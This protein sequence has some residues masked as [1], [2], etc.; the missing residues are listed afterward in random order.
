MEL[1]AQGSMRLGLG[2][3]HST[4]LF[5]SVAMSAICELPRGRETSDQAKSGSASLAARGLPKHVT[6]TWQ[7]HWPK[8]LLGPEPS[9][10][11][12]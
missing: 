9:S 12:R 8:I 6:E 3:K 7:N 2:F 10:A 1:H 11:R 5:S 4:W